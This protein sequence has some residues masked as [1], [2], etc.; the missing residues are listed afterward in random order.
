MLCPDKGKHDEKDKGAGHFMTQTGS[1]IGST[2]QTSNSPKRPK[3]TPQQA[4]IAGSHTND[5]HPRG[6]TK[7]RPMLHSRERQISSN[8]PRGKYSAET[9]RPNTDAGSPH[10]KERKK[11]KHMHLKVDAPG[12]PEST[13]LSKKKHPTHNEFSSKKAISKPQIQRGEIKCN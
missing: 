3:D 13:P 1:I 9:R 4:D 2:T 11:A 6:R 7:V 12:A 5:V 10:K 8:S